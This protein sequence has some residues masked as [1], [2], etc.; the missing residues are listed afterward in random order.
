MKFCKYCQHY[1]KSWLSPFSGNFAKC[2]RPSDDAVVNLVIGKYKSVLRYCAIER[3]FDCG[4]EAKYFEYPVKF[5]AVG[6]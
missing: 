4:V 2:V 6:D 3:D 5:R 1:R